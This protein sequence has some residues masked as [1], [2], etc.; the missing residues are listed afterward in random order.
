MNKAFSKDNYCFVISLGPKHTRYCRCL[1]SSLRYFGMN[2]LIYILNDGNTDVSQ[3]AKIKGVTIIDVNDINKQ[4]DINLIGLLSKLNFYFFPRLGY[5]YDYYVYFDADS[6]VLENF[7]D[8]F[9][10]QEFDFGILHG[11]VVDVSTDSN[12]KMFTKYAYD[13]AHDAE[14]LNS[15]ERYYFSSGHFIINKSILDIDHL[16]RH[17]HDMFSSF[18]NESSFKFFGDQG[19]LNYYVN[20]LHLEKRKILLIDIGLYGKDAGMFDYK[21]VI[22]KKYNGKSFIHYTGPSRYPFLFQHNYAPLLRFYTKL[23]YRYISNAPVLARTRDTIKETNAKD[24]YRLFR[25]QLFSRK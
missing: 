16:R 22:S 4:H 20:E 2:A 8:K 10:G 6:I 21:D 23:F 12:R 14:K 3:L 25:Y 19:Y 7:E 15:N 1:L 11:S 5:D 17:R 13:P 24:I 9:I 18:K